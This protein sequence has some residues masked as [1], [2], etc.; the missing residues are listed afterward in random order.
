MD[1]VGANTCLNL[2]VPPNREGLIDERDRKRLRE[3]GELIRQEFGTE[4]AASVEKVPG[5]PATQPVYTITLEHPVEELKYLVLKEEIEKGQRVESFRITAE[6][7]SGKLYPLYQG[8]CIGHK[9][10]CQLHDPFALQNPL[11]RDSDDK[12]SKLT[13]QITAARDEVFLKEIKVY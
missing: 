12:I 1:S 6:S 9:K 10:I 7:G 3:L 11:I 13:V 4:L 2:N 5:A 8:T